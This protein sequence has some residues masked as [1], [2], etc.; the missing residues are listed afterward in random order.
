MWSNSLQIQAEVASFFLQVIP[1]SSSSSCFLCEVS[2][3]TVWMLLMSLSLLEFRLCWNHDAAVKKWSSQVRPA[4]A[5]QLYLSGAVSSLHADNQWFTLTAA[6]FQNH[7]AR[8]SWS[9]CIEEGQTSALTLNMLGCL[10]EYPVSTPPP[11]FKLITNVL[12]QSF[13]YIFM[14][15]TPR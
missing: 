2:P 5:V 8:S 6:D 4:A 7:G 11:S 1:T 3:P 12:S 14:T 10:S 13:H 9:S 15:F